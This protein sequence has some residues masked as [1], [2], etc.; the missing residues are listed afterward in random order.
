MASGKTQKSKRGA[1]LRAVAAVLA[2]LSLLPILSIQGRARPFEEVPYDSYTYYHGFSSSVVASQ[3]PCYL[4]EKRVSGLELAV[5]ADSKLADIFTAQDGQSYVLDSGTGKIIVLDAALRVTRTID[6]IMVNGEKAD[7]KEAMGLFVKENGDIALADT[8]NKRVLVM[9]QNGTVKQIIASPAADQLP[10]GYQYLPIQV[11]VDNLG[12]YYV[13][14]KG[15]YYGAVLFSADGAFFGFFGANKIPS[16]VTGVIQ[17][18]F[19]KMFSSRQKRANSIQ[20]LP[21]EF[22]DLAIDK[23][24]FVYTISPNTP[25][26]VGQIKKLSPGSDSLLTIEA[27][28]LKKAW[29]DSYNFGDVPGYIMDD[30][31]ARQNMFASIAVDSDGY[32]YALDSVYGRIFVHDRDCNQITIFGGGVGDGT[33]LGTFKQPSALSIAGG[34][35]Y[36]L[37][38][39]TNSVTAFKRTAYGEQ[40]F[41]AQTLTN[42]GDQSAGELWRD[43]LSQNRYDQLALRGIAKAEFAAG[44]YKDALDYAKKGRD[45]ATYAR[46]FQQYRLQAGSSYF[47]LILIIVLLIAAALIILRIYLS[48]TKKVLLKNQKLRLL[49]R[50]ILHP[51]DAFDTIKRAQK[52]S[53]IIVAVIIALFYALRASSRFMSGFMYN[54][55][56]PYTYNALYTLMG[57]I[58]FAVLWMFANYGVST[59]FEGKGK[60]KDIIVVYAYSQLPM[61]AE[62]VFFIAFSHVL[63]PNEAAIFDVVY[64]VGF[65]AMIVYLL[66]GTMKIHDFSFFKTVGTALLTLLGIAV[67]AF[68]II[69]IGILFQN[70]AGFISS[71]FKEVS[72]R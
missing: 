16:T 34:R 14:S 72:L 31:S 54:W 24:G 10:E 26:G 40:V 12:F 58:G 62:L 41:K 25:Q 2:G 67:M 43:I 4:P 36:V 29:A 55:S 28:Y 13:V 68:V 63:I 42:A 46:V 64:Y 47:L 35:I 37:D 44:N 30:G 69:M 60:L 22:S 71:V 17:N 65:I 39:F 21:Y 18:L 52:G 19:D 7:I 27:G 61:L 49:F 59:L 5:G 1:V 8:A 32:F 48:K 23:S 3:R 45:H 53:L 50:M 70:L 56:D 51:F 9:D 6:R 15:S 20:K 11:V 38:Y 33:Q 57:T 66:I